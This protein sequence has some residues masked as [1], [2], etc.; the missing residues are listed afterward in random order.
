MAAQIEKMWKDDEE[1]GSRPSIRGRFPAAAATKPPPSRRRGNGAAAARQR[2]RHA[3]AAEAWAGGGS[4]TAA[5]TG[6]G[7]A[8]PHHPHLP[9]CHCRQWLCAALPA[10]EARQRRGSR[11]VAAMAPERRRPGWNQAF[12]PPFFGETVTMLGPA[13]STRTL[14][15]ATGGSSVASSR[16]FGPVGS[17]IYGMPCLVRMALHLNFTIWGING[18][19]GLRPAMPR[20]FRTE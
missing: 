7:P 8:D 18:D 1:L 15:Q 20:A 10:L 3:R 9:V 13:R 11:H 6:S 4:S 5:A 2:R 14:L 16:N 17:H 12:G 19:G